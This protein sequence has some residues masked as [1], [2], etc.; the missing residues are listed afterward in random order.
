MSRALI[1]S[2]A[3]GGFVARA[4]TSL[5]ACD[6]DATCVIVLDA[7]DGISRQVASTLMACGVDVRFGPVSG[8][9]SRNTTI[10]LRAGQRHC[11]HV[12]RQLAD[13]KSRLPGARVLFLV[14][15]FVSAQPCA[16]QDINTE[17]ICALMR[18]IGVNFVEPV[19]A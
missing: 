1:K 15:D 4:Q 9:H 17:N 5:S 2:D 12:A 7:Q 11:P 6:T 3:G 19:P 13:C 14:G 10:I 8:Q 18:E 16:Y